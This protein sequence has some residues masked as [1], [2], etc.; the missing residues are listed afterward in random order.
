MAERNG[1]KP[2]TGPEDS[3]NSRR[4]EV[5]DYLRR[6]GPL[7]RRDIIDGT[8]IPRGTMSVILKVGKDFRRDDKGKWTVK[9]SQR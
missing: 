6:N 2:A 9:E 5:K 8:G 4:K 3:K 1:V 7:R